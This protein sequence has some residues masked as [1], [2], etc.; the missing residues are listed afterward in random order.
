MPACRWGGSCDGKEELGLGQ[1]QLRETDQGGEAHS[2]ISAFAHYVIPHLPLIVSVFGQLARDEL[3]MALAPG[4]KL[5]F[6][7][8]AQ[9]EESPRSVGGEGSVGTPLLPVGVRI[10]HETYTVAG[11]II[12]E[13][14]SFRHQMPVSKFGHH[15]SS[16]PPTARRKSPLQCEGPC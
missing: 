7:Q 16:H 14:G 1:Q 9:P 2:N 12:G 8:R 11:V 13:R 5:V 6:Y 4:K 3:G 10:K 15:L